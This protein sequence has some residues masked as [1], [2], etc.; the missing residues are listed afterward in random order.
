MK[1]QAIISVAEI[2]CVCERKGGKGSA[3]LGSP[4][5]SGSC[6]KHVASMCHPGTCL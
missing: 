1:T 5:V 2:A 3:A 4:E 6:A